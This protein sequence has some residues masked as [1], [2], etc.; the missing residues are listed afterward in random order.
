MNELAFSSYFLEHGTTPSLHFSP[1]ASNHLYLIIYIPLH[2]IVLADDAAIL[3]LIPTYQSVGEPSSPL[4]GRR[5]TQQTH[6][7]E[8]DDRNPRPALHCSYKIIDDH[9]LLLH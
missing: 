7:N 8:D 5:Q 1:L 4:S 3:Q 2:L 9:N 6:E